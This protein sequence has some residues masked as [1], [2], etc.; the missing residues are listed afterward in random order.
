MPNIS[1]EQVEYILRATPLLESLPNE[2]ISELASHANGTH[3]DTGETVFAKGGS[4][5]DAYWVVTGRFKVTTSARNGSEL[6]LGMIEVGGHCGEISAIEGGPRSS[7]VIAERPSN[8]LSLNG[9]YLLA[10]IERNPKTAMK[11]VRIMAEHIRQAVTNI[12]VLGLHSAET[13]IWCRLMDLS[14]RYPGIDPKGGSVRIEHGL[15]QQGLADSVGLTRAMVNR[16]LNI[17]RDQGLIDYTRGVIVIPD[18][19]AFEAVVWR[20]PSPT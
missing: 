3:F 12:E 15:A 7:N 11:L 18:P 13:R 19:A 16:Q 8:A 4:G 2:E 9:R 14:R 6:L 1:R 10:A 5:T 17:W 20:D